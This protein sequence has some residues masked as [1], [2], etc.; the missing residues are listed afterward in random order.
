[1]WSDDKYLRSSEDPKKR[2]YLASGALPTA[3]FGLS[4]VSAVG[5]NG[6]KDLPCFSSRATLAGFYSTMDD[7][8]RAKDL[9][10]VN[11]LYQAALSL[12]I[13]LR[14]SP[15]KEQAGESG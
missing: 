10:K 7:A 15:T 4:E 1:M 12:P 13:R 6:F 9:H 5:G 3:A 8:L 2:H 11:K 14:L